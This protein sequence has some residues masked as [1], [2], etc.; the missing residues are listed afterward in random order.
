MSHAMPPCEPFAEEVCDCPEGSDPD[1]AL[2]IAT[3]I[4]WR[5]TGHRYGCCPIT[6]APCL[7]DQC[8]CPGTWE[9]RLVDGKMF[10]CCT[11]S[12]MTREQ[13]R[14]PLAPVCEITAVTIGGTVLDPSEYKLIH[15]QYIERCGDSWPTASPCGC[16]TGGCDVCEP[17]W[18]IEYLWGRKVPEDLVWATEQYA[19][20]LCLLECGSDECRLPDNIIQVSR[21]GVTQ[22]FSDPSN[23][24]V[25]GRTGL[26]EVDLIIES[27]GG[28]RRAGRVIDPLRP[29]APFDRFRVIS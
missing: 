14:L 26:P 19:S 29:K 22:V 3:N 2:R 17:A 9:P 16:G 18:T 6:V 10:N 13:V 27:L 11:N 8:S 24:V 1:R 7:P 4:L 12:G 25:E 15:H 5:L 21:Q 20:Q 28:R 23:F